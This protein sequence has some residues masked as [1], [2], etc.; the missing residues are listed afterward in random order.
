MDF[1]VHNKFPS[2]ALRYKLTSIDLYTNLE[3]ETERNKSL[4]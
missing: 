4:K 1:S 2:F 3:S